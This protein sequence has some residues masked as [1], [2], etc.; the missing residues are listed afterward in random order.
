MQKLIDNYEIYLAYKNGHFFTIE[1]CEEDAGDSDYHYDFGKCQD[2]WHAVEKILSVPWERPLV[3]ICSDS[4]SMI[5]HG[6]DL[7][8]CGEFAADMFEFKLVD[9]TNETITRAKAKLDNYLKE[10]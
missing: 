10:Q 3:T 4:V 6:K 7:R 2:E 5:D 9:S 8:K 1:K